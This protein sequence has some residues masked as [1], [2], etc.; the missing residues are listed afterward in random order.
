[1]SNRHA[2]QK[3]LLTG[4]VNGPVTSRELRM[5]WIGLITRISETSK[6]HKIVIRMPEGKIRLMR[7]KSRQGDAI[8]IDLKI[9]GV[10]FG[11]S[12]WLQQLY[13]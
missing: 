1:M 4:A 9:F 8:K 7:R 2:E 3:L 13:I 12:F 11:N 5:R 10:D 6:A